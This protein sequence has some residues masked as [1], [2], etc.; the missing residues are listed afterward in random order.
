MPPK[1]PDVASPRTLGEALRVLVY[2]AG[3]TS[4]SLAEKAGVAAQTI[5]NY[6]NDNTEPPASVLGRLAGVLAD[7]LRE[8]PA[9]LLLELSRVAEG[10]E[11]LRRIH[12]E[13]EA[14]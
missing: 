7:A 14:K 8:D 11:R 10:T 9:R 13:A 6:F 4:A 5:S 3:M 1:P 12:E 2:R